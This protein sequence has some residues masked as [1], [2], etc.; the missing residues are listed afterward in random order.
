MQKKRKSPWLFPEVWASYDILF[1]SL[2]HMTVQLSISY[3]LSFYHYPQSRG[4]TCL[5][6]TLKQNVQISEDN[7]LSL[8]QRFD[9]F[10]LPHFLL[11]QWVVVKYKGV[12]SPFVSNQY[13]QPF[14]PHCDWQAA[15]P[16]SPKGFPTAPWPGRTEP[17]ADKQLSS[18]TPTINAPC[19]HR[20]HGILNVR[21][22][23]V[24]NL[25]GLWPLPG[26][27]PRRDAS[28]AA[29]LMSTGAAVNVKACSL[30]SRQRLFL[31]HCV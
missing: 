28:P 17:A 25:L 15:V 31:V 6:D 2:A 10:Y 30:L 14:P 5:L 21:V 12:S 4:I 16:V 8:S 22:V 18:A 23:V 11:L 29:R 24:F 20:Q 1:C 9:W 27:W 19:V 3:L 26:L 13:H 7:V